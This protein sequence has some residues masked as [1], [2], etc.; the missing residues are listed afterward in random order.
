MAERP[1]I[2][3]LERLEAL[4][5]NPELYALG[6][7]VPEQDTSQGGRP[8][9]YP[10]YMW[11]LFDALL[12]VY[13]SARRV[14]AELAHPIVWKALCGWI[15]DRFPAEPEM[16]LPDRPM[17][18]HHYLYGRTRYLVADGVLEDLVELHRHH[19]AEQAREAGL[20]DPNGSG[21]WTHPDL[22]RVLYSDGKVITP[23]FKAKP[24]DRRLDRTTGELRDVRFEGDAGLHIEGTGEEAWGL[25]FVLVATRDTLPNSRY[26]LDTAWVPTAGGEARTATETFKQL[27]PHVPGA[28]AIVY[29][30]ALR[31][32]HHQTLLRELGILPV[33][34]V[35]AASG[36]R[37]QSATSTKRQRI[38]KSTFV[39]TKTITTP[40][41]ERTVRLFARG[42]QIGLSEP[43]D[44]G[45]PT[46]VPLERIRTHRNADKAGTYRWYNDYRLPVEHG[47]G[48]ITVR[49]HGND[50]DTRKKFNRTEN[51]R[52][53]PPGDPDFDRLYKRR[54]DAE[55]IN[56]HLDDTLWLRRAHSIGHRRQ[57]LNL[58][59]YAM[60]VN[61]VS[62]QLHRRRQP[63]AIAA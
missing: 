32:V 41:G 57:H 6:E 19:A 20:L 38:E 27:A 25:K 9:H 10:R 33:N 56:R 35:T 17:R 42:G 18:R 47:G 49:L 3:T 59:T 58:L 1:G 7:A 62:N 40:T 61:S 30:T 52:A 39:E 63:T 5:A 26:I 51:V 23:L 2:S 45:E 36:S 31:G 54:N 11:V 4:V 21:S 60:C 37:K 34:R 15:R 24:G 8:R 44:T 16:W 29:D 14:E 22:G 13:G 28:Q 53:I 55:S 50:D 12:S 46:F 48:G 43:T